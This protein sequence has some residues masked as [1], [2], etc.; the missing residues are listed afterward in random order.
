MGDIQNIPLMMSREQVGIGTLHDDGTMTFEMKFTT[1]PNPEVTEWGRILA[2]A[3]KMGAVFAV[4]VEVSA[5]PTVNPVIDGRLITRVDNEPSVTEVR[6]ILDVT[7]DRS[8]VFEIDV[9]PPR[10]VNGFEV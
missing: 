8:G 10:G 3:I 5:R 7:T 6:G 1:D 2:E 9:I 4:D